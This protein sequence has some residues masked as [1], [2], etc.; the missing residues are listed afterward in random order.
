MNPV[1]IYRTREIAERVARDRAR[2]ERQAFVLFRGPNTDHIVFPKGAV[3][4]EAHF[5]GG[6]AS[7]KEC[8]QIE[9]QGQ[10]S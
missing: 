8:G 3:L 9:P 5:P 6:R 10:E 2:T 4:T 7:W 1:T